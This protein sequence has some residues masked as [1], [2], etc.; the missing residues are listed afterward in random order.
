M[1]KA[2]IVRIQLIF[3]GLLPAA[4]VLAQE[5]VKKQTID[6]TSAFKPAVKAAA[7]INFDAAP[8]V[9]D[10][11]RPRFTYNT[12]VTSLE[13]VYEPL[14]ISPLALHT[15]T[16]GRWAAS[17]Y[18]KL[19][20]GNYQ[21]P[22][23]EAGLTFTN[24]TNSTLSVL[25]NFI[26]SKSKAIEHQSYMN[27]RARAYGSTIINGKH[28][29]YGN[30]SFQN[31]QYNLYGYDHNLF[32]YD[33][34]AVRQRFIGLDLGAGFR[35]TEETEF[36]LKYHPDVKVSFFND[37]YHGREFRVIGNL[38]LSKS[39]GDAFAI[40]LALNAD[41]NQFSR[42]NT[43][44]LDNSIFTV[45]LSLDFKNENLNIHGGVIP[46]WDNSQFRLLPDLMADLKLGSDGAILQMGWL[47]HYDKATYKRF[48]S[49]NPYLE[50]PNFLLNTRVNETYGGLKGTFLEHFFYN[51]KVGLVRFH[52]M[53]LFVNDTLPGDR[54]SFVILNEERLSA[55]QS[56]GEIGIVQAEEFSLTAK[57]DWL[58]F[59]GQKTQQEAWGIIPRE[60]SAALRWRVLK[61]LWLKSDL[62]VFEGAKFM[63]ADGSVGR[64]RSPF[65]LNAGLEFKVT[66]QFNLWVQANN[67]F[68]TRYQRW[69][70]YDVFGFN[71]LGGIVFNF[72][73]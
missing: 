30:A 66:K 12:P 60:L 8:P 16:T 19:G 47:M 42:R 39:I 6:I 54:K 61:D 33:K 38:P 71:I 23:A 5:P 14:T 13:R 53:P 43:P 44:A 45:P 22:Y 70:Q 7:K 15:D 67:V 64:G 56:H 2:N 4:F 29:L 21:T 51:V 11:A 40:N 48:A 26:S 28:E 41:Y 18:V 17:N 32:N 35:N 34:A 55:F 36:G 52:N 24:A 27:M 3:A 65:D 62:F 57:F 73:K 1:F 10:S 25:G 9:P 68:N 63:N 20:F 58:L 69:N 37:N 59:S 46:S 50:Q 31:D 49:I 72:S